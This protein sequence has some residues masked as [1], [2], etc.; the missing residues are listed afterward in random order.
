MEYYIKVQM[1]KSILLFVVGIVT[2]VLI[3]ALIE[4]PGRDKIERVYETKEEMLERK[5]RKKTAGKVYFVA[6]VCLV[7][8]LNVV[9]YFIYSQ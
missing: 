5:K 4:I 8:I 6:L 9:W 7:M 1:G 2:Y 3:S